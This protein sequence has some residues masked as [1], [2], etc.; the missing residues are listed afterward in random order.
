MSFQELIAKVSAQPLRATP[1]AD[2]QARLDKLGNRV[3]DPFHVFLGRVA[4]HETAGVVWKSWTLAATPTFRQ[5]AVCLGLLTDGSSVWHSLT[6]NP[7]GKVTR[8]AFGE[9]TPLGEF[10]HFAAVTSELPP[11]A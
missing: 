2:L 8:S 9:E 1:L 5:G 3:A 6:S 10:P 4:R 7:L 11:P